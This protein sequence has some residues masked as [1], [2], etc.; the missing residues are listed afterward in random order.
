MDNCQHDI[1]QISLIVSVF[2]LQR[3]QRFP[4]QPCPAC[5][6]NPAPIDRQS[7]RLRIGSYSSVALH[8]QAQ[9]RCTDSTRPDRSRGPPDPEQARS[10]VMRRG[11]GTICIGAASCD[12]GETVAQYS[13]DLPT[14]QPSPQE[15]PQI[16]AC[17]KAGTSDDQGQCHFHSKSNTLCSSRVPLVGTF[18]SG[19][20]PALII[21]IIRII[22]GSLGR[23]AFISPCHAAPRSFSLTPRRS[24]MSVKY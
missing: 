17:Q 10:M 23:R 8:S 5:D 7:R 4:K 2:I 9:T 1:M 19:F 15:S 6:S 22:A 24:N 12:E 21:H 14:D 13:H 11:P 3:N 18:Q 16:S 20:L